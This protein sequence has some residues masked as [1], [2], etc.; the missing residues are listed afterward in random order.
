MGS[1]VTKNDLQLSAVYFLRARIE[2]YLVI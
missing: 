2:E 1:N